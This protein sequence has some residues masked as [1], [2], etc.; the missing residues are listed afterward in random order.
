MERVEVFKYLG[1]LLAY[2]VNDARAVK[3]NL[4]KVQGIWAQ[5]SHTIRS[6]NASPRAR[7]VFY[8]ATVQSILMVGSETWNLSPV[9]LKS[10]E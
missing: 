2:N 5:L 9:S 4:K 8:K 6:K 3:R 10:L 7:G 1:R